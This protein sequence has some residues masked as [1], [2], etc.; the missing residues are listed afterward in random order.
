MVM[1]DDPLRRFAKTIAHL[2]QCLVVLEQAALP[3]HDLEFVQ[4]F[5][6][7]AKSYLAKDVSPDTE[8][9]ENW[10][11]PENQAMIQRFIAHVEQEIRLI[12]EE[13][14]Q[15]HADA[16]YASFHAQLAALLGELESEPQGL[17]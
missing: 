1:S 7:H 6:T 17:N 15:S 10:S 12:V 9:L 8:A 16:E 5:L 13:W 11:T 2:E 3:S 14:Q 4:T